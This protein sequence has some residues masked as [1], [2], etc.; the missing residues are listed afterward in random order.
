MFCGN[1]TVPGVDPRPVLTLE[2][3]NSAKSISL[4]ARFEENFRLP[5]SCTKTG[6]TSP[7][8]KT[9]DSPGIP[10]R[11]ML[12]RWGCLALGARGEPHCRGK[13][14]ADVRKPLFAARRDGNA[15][16]HS[17]LAL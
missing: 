11:S 4:Y 15:A 16:S 12:D 17:R 13:T 7:I 9:A 6:Q 14:E 5:R 10:A 2:R 1:R 8:K 3:K